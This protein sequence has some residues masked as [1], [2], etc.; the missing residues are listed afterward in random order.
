[1]AFEFD[2]DDFMDVIELS[3]L[4]NK[5]NAG[6]V[7][8]NDKF[9]YNSVDKYQVECKAIGS[10]NSFFDKVLFIDFKDLIHPGSIQIVKPNELM[11]I[12]ELYFY[13]IVRM[14]N[15]HNRVKFLIY[16]PEVV[17]NYKKMKED[18]ELRDSTIEFLEDLIENFE[19]IEDH[20]I[21][22][23]TMNSGGSLIE[24]MCMPAI[25]VMKWDYAEENFLKRSMSVKE[26][27]RNFKKILKKLKEVNF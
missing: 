10:P 6:L 8:Y 3:I 21:M 9:K 2:K 22:M 23:S 16:P 25:S 27:V 1:M 5:I 4:E 14:I 17:L 24:M 18:V 13:L 7:K 26:Y 11:L 15:E 19:K 20:C 12:F